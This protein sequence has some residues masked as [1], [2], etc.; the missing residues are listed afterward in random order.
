MSAL[1]LA[2]LRTLAFGDLASGLWGLVWSAGETAAAI[3]SL[4]PGA[5]A[6]ETVGVALDGGGAETEWRVEDAIVALRA[7][8]AGPA[9]DPA[10]DDGGW[11]QLCRVEGRLTVGGG[12][13][14][15]DCLGVRSEQAVPEL[16][17]LEG[18]RQVLAWFAD[19][20]ALALSAARPRGAPGQD[21]DEL[22]ATVFEPRGPARANDARLSTTYAEGGAPARIGLELWL[23][24]EQDGDE[25]PVR[26]AGEALGPP[27]TA[28][29][30]GAT[31]AINPMLAHRGGRDGVA[32]YLL[33][34]P[35]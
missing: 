16:S 13:R 18:F 33:A 35:A 20:D 22:S 28:R 4:T 31:L 2:P 14:A 21:R 5:P 9:S 8:A 27:A 29:L 26:A 17:R 32:T 23:P 6:G 24:G 3:G 25:Y 10:A 19:D 1:A 30:S 11:T 12:E 7:A 34:R 15:L